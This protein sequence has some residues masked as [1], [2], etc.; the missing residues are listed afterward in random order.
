MRRPTDDPDTCARLD[1]WQERLRDEL[2]LGD[3]P[4]D[5]GRILKLAEVISKQVARPAVPVSGYIVGMAIGAAMARGQD[6][7]QALN[8][9]FGAA[10]DPAG[11]APDLP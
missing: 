11:T 2:D 9:A 10:M 4:C 6:V 3:A 1:H 5:V 7:E 8:R